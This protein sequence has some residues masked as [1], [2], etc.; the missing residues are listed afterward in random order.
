MLVPKERAANHVDIT[1]AMHDRPADALISLNILR[2]GFT[3]VDDE[4]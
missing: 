1:A 4:R 3:G 2:D